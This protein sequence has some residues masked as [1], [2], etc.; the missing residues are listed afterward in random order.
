MKFPS[1]NLLMSYRVLFVIAVSCAALGLLYVMIFDNF[2][3]PQWST[4]FYTNPRMYHLNTSN[5]SKYI[6][7]A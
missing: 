3:M 2:L 5:K 7:S 4:I 6:K 1:Q